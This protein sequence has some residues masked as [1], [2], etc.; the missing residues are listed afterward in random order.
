MVCFNCGAELNR[1][2]F[3]TSCGADV[4]TY[5]KIMSFANLYYNEALERVHVRD[6]SGAV[7]SL[8]QCLKLD[9][10]HVDARN[11]LG[12]VYFEMGEVVEAFI[13]WVISKN[14]RPTKNIAD[15]YIN[16]I[17]NNP[18]GLESLSASIKKYN[19][20]L[21]DC[22][23]GCLDVGMIAVKAAI[24]CNPNFVKARQ[25]K[26]LMH[27][28]AERKSEY[29]EARKELLKCKEIDVGNTTTLRYLSV[30][31]SLL[32]ID[33][34][35]HEPKNKKYL[36]NDSVSYSIGN[37]TIIQPKVSRVS[38]TSS[39]IINIV[40]GFAIGIAAACLLILPARVA[41][42]KEGVDDSLK[43]ANEQLDSKT[44]EIA[45]LDQNVKSLEAQNA[46][47]N[48]QLEMYIGEDGTATAMDSLLGA[49]SSYLNSPEDSA[50]VAEYLDKIDAD[51]L[52]QTSETFN[53]VYNML[54]TKVGGEVGGNYYDSGMKAYQAENYEE[55][56][57]N[58]TKAYA[59]DSSNEDALFNLGN[60]YRKL[61][62]TINALDTYSKV[63]ELFPDTERATRAQQY[64]NELNV[65]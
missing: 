49:V 46:K 5:K 31:E 33:G 25:L 26:A 37:E 24:L 59:Y 39:T 19:M 9:K 63:I 51:T 64:I 14:L 30:V 29:V 38:Q 15:N 7:E 12:L 45:E 65:D 47:L 22:Y 16:A 50:T 35:L 61:G 21:D 56:V 6:L 58:L 55:A 32:N 40:I 34:N 54:L 10:N 48:S 44:A 28:Q 36:K 41:A 52:S 3:C 18:E 4:K 13:Q 17:Q 42:A 62:D 11:L 27:I 43:V 8:R 23:R 57:L 53:A 60:A 1:N 20:A 2:D